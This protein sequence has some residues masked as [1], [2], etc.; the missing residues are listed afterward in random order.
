MTLNASG[1]ISLGGATTGQ[2]I[3]LEL[4]VSATALASINATNFRTL[5]G[6]A[7]GQISL[8]NF[9]GKSNVPAYYVTSS[10]TA[11]SNMDSSYLVSSGNVYI[12]ARYPNATAG[13]LQGITKI[14]PDG[15]TA[16]TATF[17]FLYSGGDERGAI[18]EDSS[19]NVYF[20]FYSY[21]NGYIYSYK[22]NSS[23]TVQ[24]TK[25]YQPSGGSSS[26]SGGGACVDTSGNS[27][28][29][30]STGGDLVIMKIDNTGAIAYCASHSSANYSGGFS[31][32]VTPVVD[33]SG[34]V[35]ANV[36]TGTN[37]LI[38]KFTGSTG[39]IALHKKVVPVS[40]TTATLSKSNRNITVA[41][42]G[43]IYFCA[44]PS[45]DYQTIV[46]M[47]ASM[48]IQ[49]AYTSAFGL[50]YL[51]NGPSNGVFSAV[52][53]NTTT[54][55]FTPIYAIQYASITSAGAVSY[56]NTILNTRVP[57]QNNYTFVKG[58]GNL[59]TLVT[60]QSGD[61]GSPAFAIKLPIDNSQIGA[62]NINSPN[63]TRDYWNTQIYIGPGSVT[64]N[65]VSMS[66][67]TVTWTTGTRSPTTTSTSTSG[68]L[69]TAAFT[70]TTLTGLTGNSNTYSIPGTYSWVAPTG[71]T[72]VSV[73]AVGGGGGS[74]YGSGGGGGAL[75][76]GNNIAVTA[77]SSYTVIVGD[78]GYRAQSS[79]GGAGGQ[80][81]F[82]VGAN[83]MAAGGGTYGGAGGTRTGGLSTGGG[84][85]G[86][87]TNQ[88]GGGA[89]GYSGAGGAGGS[90]SGSG[91][92][93]GAGAGGAAGGGRGGNTVCGFIN[94]AWGGGGTG[95]LGLGNDGAGGNATNY[96][97]GSNGG[98]TLA[99]YQPG[100]PG[101][102][103]SAGGTY[104]CCCAGTVYSYGTYGAAGAVRIV[105]PGSSRSFP[106]TNV[107][108][109]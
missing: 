17:S 80:S 58:D 84:T 88:G 50:F 76:Y 73:V 103:G 55:Q 11:S 18:G 67:T 31:F 9:Y 70:A 47:N 107:G 41:S 90:S 98:S 87:G 93:G 15:S 66:D 49:W 77:G 40:G 36:L 5:A 61:Y 69:Y 83:F 39:A 71:V 95:L 105:W 64:L 72:S 8:S 48:V 97:G 109:L 35:Y 33:S 23:G 51:S 53:P 4:G 81:R 29:V 100:I 45:G 108:S 38:V 52:I 43:S 20:T 68:G 65:A 101:G 34:N 57:Q 74:T 3:N 44:K 12:I 24:Y 78:G 63:T 37:Q 7:S 28:V 14:N 1:P 102:G 6:V 26:W 27:Y 42:D 25:Y 91:T 32:Q 54:V 62:F 10:S 2:S 85:G 89:G 94:T 79:S 59:T 75:N 19:G 96:N 60:F 86:S 16:W 99:N 22:I 106:S 104:Y 21:I 82:T 30:T 46:K 13:Y 92:N 56:A